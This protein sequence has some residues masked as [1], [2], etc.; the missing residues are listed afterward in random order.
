MA[1]CQHAYLSSL[2]PLSRSHGQAPTL[3]MCFAPCTLQRLP[4]SPDSGP[5]PALPRSSLPPRRRRPRLSPRRRLARLV[6]P[7]ASFAAVPWHPPHEWRPRRIS[8]LSLNRLPCVLCCAAPA[9]GASS[10]PAAAP[11]TQWGVTPAST[12]AF[13]ELPLSPLPTAA[14][15]FVSV[16]SSHLLGNSLPDLQ[17]PSTAGC[18]FCCVSVLC[19]PISR[20]SS[21][22]F[23][24]ISMAGGFGASAGTTP[25]LFGGAP[26]ASSPSLFGASSP[27]FGAGE[28]TCE[29]AGH[30]PVST[31]QNLCRFG[32][33]ADKLWRHILFTQI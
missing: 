11:T 10:T 20:S 12:P 14:V 9:F 1:C 15:Y 26:A 31:H 29:L 19:A 4:P 7:F 28:A 18:C 30:N 25:S 33:E 23:C 6:S 2:D 22:R 5:P 13:G 16:Q 24:L 32:W 27:A 8:S 21:A 3:A 17:Q